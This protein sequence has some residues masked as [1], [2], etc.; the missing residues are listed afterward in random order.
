MGPEASWA[1]VPS[2][3]CMNTP[4]RGADA[5]HLVTERAPPGEGCRRQEGHPGTQVMSGEGGGEIGTARVLEAGKTWGRKETGS[6]CCSQSRVVLVVRIWLVF[7][8]VMLVGNFIIAKNRSQLK[9]CL[10]PK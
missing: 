2:S 7:L 5:H 1:A 10:A 4:R 8:P 9:G 6:A 3:V